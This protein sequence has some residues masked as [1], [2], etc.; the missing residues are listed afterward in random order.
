MKYIVTKP[1]RDPSGMRLPGE[2]IELSPSRVAALRGCGLIGCEYVEKEAERPD[3][4]SV[5]NEPE[6]TN[7]P[8]AAKSNASRKRVK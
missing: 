5:N 7:N 2:L 8:E 3:D 1:F 4:N 6:K